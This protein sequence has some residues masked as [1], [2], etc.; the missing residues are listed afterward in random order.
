MDVHE[1]EV[2]SYNMSRI[3]GKDCFIELH[4]LFSIFCVMIDNLAAKPYKKA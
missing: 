1:P 2:R 4:F 3:K